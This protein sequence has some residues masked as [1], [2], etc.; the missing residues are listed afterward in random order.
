MED[1]EALYRAM[2]GRMYAARLIGD[3]DRISIIHDGTPSCSALAAA[4]AAAAWEK[5][6]AVYTEPVEVEKALVVLSP[7]VEGM[8]QRAA[9]I[10][11]KVKRFVA[12]H[13]PVFYALDEVPDAASLLAGKEVRF[14][15]RET[16]GEV[17]FYRVY[18]E[19][20][21]IRTEAYYRWILSDREAEVVRKFEER[22]KK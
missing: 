3:V 13:T 4:V 7:R 10:L 21:E 11:K 14:A 12:L 15:V 19:G 5:V 8:P 18:V 17:T 22:M 9:A 20:G 2:L 6:E 1:V 16:P